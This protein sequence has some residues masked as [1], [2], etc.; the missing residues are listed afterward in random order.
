MAHTLPPLPY[1]MDALAPHI[2]SET[3]SFH[4]GKHHQAYVTNLNGLIE[5]SEFKDMS[6]VDIMM[7]TASKT[8]DVIG[9]FNN[10]AQ[11]YNHTFFWHSM[12]PTSQKSELNGKLKELIDRDL[13]GI[14]KFKEEFKKAATTQFGS[15]WAWLVYNK[16]SQKL[17]IMKTGNADCPLTQGLIP[18]LTCDV[19][20]HAYYID[21]Q[22][23]RPDYVQTFLDHLI[24]YE[25]GNEN[26]IKAL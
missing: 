25:F 12:H 4:H 17:E 19:W 3:L 21:Y 18:I 23:R 24:N 15:G 20:E 14:E 1:A 9:I 13:G 7:K 8:P 6:L 26:L 2:S 16:N 10:A 5:N 11:V 22:N